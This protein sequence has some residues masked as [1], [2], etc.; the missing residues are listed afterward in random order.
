MC[1]HNGVPWVLVG[2]RA[3]EAFGRAEFVACHLF[4]FAGEGGVHVSATGFGLD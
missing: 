1:G 3:V 2:E 4:A